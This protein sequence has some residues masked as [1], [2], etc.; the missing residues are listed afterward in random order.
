MTM[1]SFPK[2]EKPLIVVGSLVK[3]EN[4]DQDYHSGSEDMIGKVGQVIRTKWGKIHVQFPDE[5]IAVFKL[6]NLS[7]I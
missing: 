5:S 2:K 7:P 6:E 4:T 3:V 1:Q